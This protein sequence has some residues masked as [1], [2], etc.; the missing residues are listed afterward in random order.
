ML[1]VYGWGMSWEKLGGYLLVLL[2]L[3]AILI[4]VAAVFGWLLNKLRRSDQPRFNVSDDAEA[5]KDVNK[6]ENNQEKK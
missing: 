4:A 2:I 1:A 6:H 3:L 5:A